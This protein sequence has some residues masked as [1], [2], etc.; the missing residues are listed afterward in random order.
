MA[1]TVKSRNDNVSGFL[2]SSQNPAVQ[3]SSK[4]KG[5]LLLTKN[6]FSSFINNSN[7]F[8]GEIEEASNYY[9]GTVTPRTQAYQVSALQPNTYEGDQSSSA[10]DYQVTVTTLREKGYSTTS[11]TY[12]FLINEF[13]DFLVTENGDRL[14]THLF[15]LIIIEYYGTVKKSIEYTTTINVRNS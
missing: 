15:P 7:A 3:V 10:P 6:N 12:Y 2:D 1:P 14:I 9:Q 4:E 5:V 8:F 11:Q 13:S